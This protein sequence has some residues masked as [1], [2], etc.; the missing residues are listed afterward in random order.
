MSLKSYTNNQAMKHANQYKDL[1]EIVTEASE[2][3]YKAG[4][5]KGLKT[6]AYLLRTKDAWDTLA[7]NE[8]WGNIHWSSP[9]EVAAYLEEKIKELE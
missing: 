1:G 9:E 5:K 7:R 4:F 3:D 8:T 6:A 2:F